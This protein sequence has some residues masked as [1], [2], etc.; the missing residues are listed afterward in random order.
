MPI[1]NRNLKNTFWN[2][3][4]TILYPVA[5]L[6]LTPFFLKHLGEKMFGVYMLS[7]SILFSLQI[8]N[9]GLGTATIRN[10][11]RFWGQRDSKGISETINVNLSFSL[12]LFALC[13]IIGGIIALL[14]DYA[15]LF[16]IESGLKNYT[17]T[18][19]F[20]AALIGGLKF[21]EQ[22]V[23][24][25]FKGFERFD[26]A[27]WFNIS[28][29]VGILL[30]N[31]LMVGLFKASVISMLC[32]NLSITFTLFLAQLYSLQKVFPGYV[33]Q[34]QFKKS[35]LLEELNFGF[36]IWLQSLLMIITYQTDRYAVTYLG[37]ETLSYYALTA[38][39]F[40]HVYMML[41]SLFP[42]LFPRIAVMRSQ[43]QD[44]LPLFKTIRSTMA[45]FGIISLSC[46]FLLREPILTLWVG[47]DKFLK[48]DQF[49]P[50]FTGFEM[51]FILTIVPGAFLNSAGY[52]KLWF[53]I[54]L[55]YGL[56]TIAAILTCFF[57]SHSTQ[58]VIVGL[59]IGAALS[60]LIM[61]YGMLSITNGGWLN[62]IILACLPPFAGL[63]LVLANSRLM[64]AFYFVL[65]LLT[66]R[67]V[68]F[69]KQN[70]DFKW[71][72]HS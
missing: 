4:D 5:V 13:A 62:E 58:G 1:A 34:I 45:A 26:I 9:M 57:I 54:N 64:Q 55:A 18:C 12:V 32:V 50:L 7:F 8:L 44:A 53:R 29:R 47:H 33:F 23:Q 72:K 28:V 51:F 31:V 69:T 71:L 35:R 16:N 52:E 36:W 40:N 63:L 60:T 70:F 56:L 15:G 39:I 21:S 14:V 65:I 22:I 66:L 10:V 43:N 27:A 46:F 25:S 61:Q 30:T 41:G 67:F 68:Y 37:L 42:W 11:A 24:F 48:L 19:V 49:I 20:I 59:I 17:A 2:M 3:V 6:G 38:T